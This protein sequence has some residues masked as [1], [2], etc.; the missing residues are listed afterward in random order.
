MRAIRVLTGEHASRP[1][2]VTPWRTA[3]DAPAALHDLCALAAAG[4]S[5][6]T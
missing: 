4:R 5:P 1:D 6:L 2:V 3:P